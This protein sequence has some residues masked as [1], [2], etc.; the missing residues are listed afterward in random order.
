MLERPDQTIGEGRDVGKGGSPEEQPRDLEAL[1]EAEALAR[2]ESHNR[3]MA[4]WSGSATNW[5]DFRGKMAVPS[6]ALNGS[7]QMP[8]TAMTATT[9]EWRTQRNAKALPRLKR[10][11]PA[12]FPRMVLAHALARALIPPTPRR[13]VE[14]YWRHHPVR[15]DRLARAL[16]R[17]GRAPADWVWRLAHQK[18][19]E[20]AS[21][22]LPPM[23]FRERAHAPAAG[24]CC[25]CGQPV[26]RYGWH[27]DLWNEGPS[28]RAAW[29]ACCVAAWN[30]WTAPSN[31][32]QHLKKLQN[33]RCGLTGARLLKTAEV[34]HRVPLFQVWR[35]HREAG[36]P[37]LL[38]FWGVPNLQVVNRTAHVEKCAI[39]TGERAALRG[40]SADRGCGTG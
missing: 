5:Q 34:D 16:A 4:L 20:P 2:G 11:L 14:S 36:W 28:P 31:Y 35:D 18:T 40:G 25:I 32:I 39:E 24:D 12:I 15:A 30:L 17:Q 10:S 38:A 37:A 6:Q 22:R 9:S 27:R 23:P 29:H 19:G 3:R 33:R 8:S 21:F 13:A 1:A 26:F 7:P